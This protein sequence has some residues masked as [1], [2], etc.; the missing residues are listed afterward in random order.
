MKRKWILV[1]A[2]MLIGIAGVFLILRQTPKQNLIPQNEEEQTRELITQGNPPPF[3]RSSTADTQRVDKAHKE[4]V[5]EGLETIFEGLKKMGAVKEAPTA[6]ET[7]SNAMAS[8]DSDAIRRAFHEVTYGRFAQMSESIPAMKTHLDSPAPYVRYLAAEALLRV[9]D[10]SG[11]EVLIELLSNEKPVIHEGSDLRL[12]SARILGN[13]A[14]SEASL[15]LQDLYQNTEAGSVLNAL[16]HIQKNSASKQLIDAIKAKRSPGFVALN[17][18][19]I[20]AEGEKAFL[21]ETFRN[22]AVPNIYVEQTK[23][24]AAWALARLTVDEKYINFLS[25]SARS[26]IESD[27]SEGLTYDNSTKA[28]QYLG[29]VQ[30]PQAVEVLE[31]ALE[32]QNPVAVQYAAVNLL[33]NQPN[34]SQKAEQLVLDEF[35]NFPNMLGPELAMQIASKSSS[36]EIREAA[37]AYAKRTGSD[38]WRYWGEE[39]SDWPVENWVYDYV[40]TLNR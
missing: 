37:E 8:N 17:L 25:E 9:G 35:R 1:V 26:A 24:A 2:A 34:I 22:P 32:S 10:Q 6:M 40:V 5:Q 28:I 3:S 20:N 18:G 4:E 11:V 23:A 29:S 31:A 36:S 12:Q 27:A 16:A 33:F 13:N 38:R 39:R 19:L 15:T 21:E 30:S 7:L 14:I